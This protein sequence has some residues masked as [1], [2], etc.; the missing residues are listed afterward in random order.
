MIRVSSTAA[1][2]L[3]NRTWTVL[4]Q[5]RLATKSE[6]ILF[7]Q[8]RLVTKLSAILFFLRRL[9]F[10]SGFWGTICVEILRIVLKTQ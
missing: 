10:L 6:A 9:D 8:G 1:G 5:G 3:D 2:N 4:R 7:W